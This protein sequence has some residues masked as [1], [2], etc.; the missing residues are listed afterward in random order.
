MALKLNNF[1]DKIKE[2]IRAVKW[3]HRP[4]YYGY[5]SD[6]LEKDLITAKIYS[7]NEDVYIKFLFPEETKAERVQF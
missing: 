5:Y 3:G 7:I 2:D 6:Y 1:S 4:I